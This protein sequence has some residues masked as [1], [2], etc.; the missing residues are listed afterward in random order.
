MTNSSGAFSQ[1][2]WGLEY[3]QKIKIKKSVFPLKKIVLA[4][5]ASVPALS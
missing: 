4:A 1:K 5:V 3:S 2:D